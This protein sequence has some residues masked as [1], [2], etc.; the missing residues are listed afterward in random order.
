[1]VE[2]VRLEHNNVAVV[3]ENSDA[4]VLIDLNEAG[5]L[6]MNYIGLT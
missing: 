4:E 5:R 3:S 1:M 2:V 6:L